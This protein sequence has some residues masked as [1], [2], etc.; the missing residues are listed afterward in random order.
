V[1]AYSEVLQDPARA[2]ATVQLYRTFLL[3]ESG[4]VGAGRY[5]D[6]RLV[7]PTRM[8]NGAVDLVSSPALLSGWEDCADDMSSEVVERCGHFVPE[9]VPGL[10]AQRARA[11]FG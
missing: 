1:R 7:V 6:A 10:V 2:R 3:R 4:Q 9:E 8:V 11:L 5:R